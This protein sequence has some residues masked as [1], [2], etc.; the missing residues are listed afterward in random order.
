MISKARLGQRIDVGDVKQ[1][2]LTSSSRLAACVMFNFSGGAQIPA[3]LENAP[4]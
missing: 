2:K 4:L 1:S 3:D